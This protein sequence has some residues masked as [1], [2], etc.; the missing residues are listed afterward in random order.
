MQFRE[1]MVLKVIPI[2]EWSYR[3]KRTYFGIEMFIAT[4]RIYCMKVQLV[5]TRKFLL[6]NP[7]ESRSS[8]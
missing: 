2:I 4:D 8:G 7:V 5:N 3:T 6:L 1:C